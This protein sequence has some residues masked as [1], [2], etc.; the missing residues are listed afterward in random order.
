MMPGSVD[1]NLSATS[2]CW[3]KSAS[4]STLPRNEQPVRMTSIGCAVFGILSS[5]SFTDFGST[6]SFF[7]FA[8]YA[9]SCFLLGSSP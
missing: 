7:S 6:R 1:S 5:T 3:L 2:C 9:S 4:G 8:L